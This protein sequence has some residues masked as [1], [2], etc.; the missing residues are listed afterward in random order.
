MRGILLAGASGETRP[1][2]SHPVSHPLMPVFDKPMIYY[3]L[4]TLMQA[5][6]REVLVVVTPD[7]RAAVQRLLGDGSSLGMRLEYAVQQRP[8]GIPHA[9]RLGAEF[10]GE[11]P[12]ALVLGDQLLHGPGVGTA[13]ATHHD[14]QGAHVFAHRVR[15]PQDYG[16]IELDRD[17]RVLSVEEKPRRPRSDHAVPGLYFFDA[18]AVGIATDLRPGV[19]GRPEITAV[20]EVYRR[21]GRLSVTVLGPQVAWLDTGGV[22]SAAAATEFVRTVE[23]RQGHK[24]G[25]VEEIAW[26]QGWITTADLRELAAERRGT[27]YGDY[28]ALLA[29]ER[30]EGVVLELPGQRARPARTR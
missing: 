26:R 25:C 11:E 22:D 13:L 12:V 23:V 6:L 24:V 15:N 7:D 29:G 20:L 9:L 1:T 14:V 17:G 19:R 28:L 18:E 8:E 16:V 4:A 3:P 27:G 2:L 5:D 10:A 30:R 21:L